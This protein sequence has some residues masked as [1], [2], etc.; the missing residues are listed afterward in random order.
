MNWLRTGIGILYLWLYSL[1]LLPP[2]C[3]RKGPELLLAKNP[4]GYKKAEGLDQ[5][6]REEGW[7]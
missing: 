5:I 3:C 2:V 1:A 7:E 6:K 4:A